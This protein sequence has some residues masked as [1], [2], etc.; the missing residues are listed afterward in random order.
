MGFNT[1]L[2]HVSIN[3]SIRE[4][5]RVLTIYDIDIPVDVARKNM[6]SVFMANARIQGKRVVDM[7]VEKAYMDL[8]ETLLQW[9][10]RPHLLR[11]FDGVVKDNP[12][13]AQRKKPLNIEEDFLRS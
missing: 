10:Q 7:L 6:K 2:F 8:E 1:A 4:I 13:G 3:T 5:P 11:L 9:K 12:T